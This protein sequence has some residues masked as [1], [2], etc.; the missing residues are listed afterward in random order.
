MLADAAE[1]EVVD[2]VFPVS[3]KRGTGVDAADRPGSP[4]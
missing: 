4:S 2:E 3:A 1:L